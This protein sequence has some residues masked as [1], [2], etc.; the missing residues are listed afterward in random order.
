MRLSESQSADETVD[1]SW[2]QV[3]GWARCKGE[4]N[5][6]NWRIE[7]SRR[8]CEQSKSSEN[9]SSPSAQ[10]TCSKQ[11]SFFEA[12]ASRPSP[13]SVC[14]SHLIV[15]VC[16]LYASYSLYSLPTSTPVLAPDRPAVIGHRSF[17]ESCQIKEVVLC[18]AGACEF[19]QMRSRSRCIHGI[20]RAA[21][22]SSG[23]AEVVQ[24]RFVGTIL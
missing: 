16:I 12:S 7:K 11:V 23:V 20:R 8:E 9:K 21:R 1:C 22:R 24:I 18:S 15:F 2:K 6:C 13:L 19:D 3:G 17:E 10:L 4:R 14:P 5:L